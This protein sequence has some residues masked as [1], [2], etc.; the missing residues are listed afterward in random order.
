MNLANQ[1]ALRNAKAKVPTTASG[2]RYIFVCRDCTTKWVDG[3]LA[4]TMAA[5]EAHEVNRLHH[6]IKA[7][8]LGLANGDEYVPPR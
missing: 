2:E 3:D 6:V 8:I 4:W 1:D 5:V 7:L